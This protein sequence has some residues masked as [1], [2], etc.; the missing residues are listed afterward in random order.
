[1]LEF[2]SSLNEKGIRVGELRVAHGVCKTPMYM[3]VG[4]VGS[5]KAVSP[6]ELRESGVEMVLGNTYHLH[7]RPGEELVEKMGGL[8]SFMN[9][10]GP[11]LTD[12]GGFQVFSLADRTKMDEDGVSF[13]SHIDGSLRRLDAEKSIA[14]QR[15]LGADI[16]MAFDECTP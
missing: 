8:A 15:A 5:V 11:T 12:S 7:L 2:S 3:A 1:M 14:I 16:I 10:N 6:E 9:W 4:T 13:S